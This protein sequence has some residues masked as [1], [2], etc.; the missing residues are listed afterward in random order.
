[1]IPDRGA[2]LGIRVLG[3]AE[4]CTRIR[5]ATD[6]ELEG[7]V[8]NVFVNDG[9]VASKVERVERGVYFE[10]TD[11]GHAMVSDIECAGDSVVQII[12]VGDPPHS[13]LRALTDEVARTVVGA[14][15]KP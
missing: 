13:H 15:A 2:A 14:G 11:N 6:S 5:L 1:V 8:S 10:A 7:L 3:D 4:V 12:A 9:L